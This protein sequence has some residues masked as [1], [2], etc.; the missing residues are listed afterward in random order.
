MI[1]LIEN[2]MAAGVQVTIH[3]H[4]SYVYCDSYI[5]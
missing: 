1:A 3:T 5:E 4:T 2:I